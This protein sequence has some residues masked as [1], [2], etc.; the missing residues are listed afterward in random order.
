MTT[1]LAPHVD[2]SLPL[3]KEIQDQEKSMMENMKVRFHMYCGGLES[4]S[5][6][7]HLRQRIFCRSQ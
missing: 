5:F 1:S 4:R 2:R 7:S 6:E 3:D